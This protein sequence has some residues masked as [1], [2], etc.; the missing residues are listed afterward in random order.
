[1][2]VNLRAC[3]IG[4]G[5]VRG[6]GVGDERGQ[7]LGHRLCDTGGGP[8]G[9]LPLLRRALRRL[10]R[11]CREGGHRLD[12]AQCGETVQLGLAHGPG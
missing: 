7:V 8:L 6:G 2:L 9:Q 3:S 12:V 1:M 4:I 10:L 5:T 11:G